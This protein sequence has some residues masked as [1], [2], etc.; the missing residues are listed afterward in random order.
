LILGDRY[1]GNLGIPEVVLDAISQYVDVLSVQYF[2]E[3]TAE[4]RRK[5]RE[6]LEGW[7]RRCGKPVLIADIGNWC[8]THHNPERVSDLPDQRARAEDY[9]AAFEAV[10]D[11][12]WLIGWHW[13]SY[14]ENYTRGWG[15]K[16]PEDNPYDEL[17]GPIEEYNKSFLA[18][19]ANG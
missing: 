11:A 1:N 10:A 7:H 18:G 3:P 13:C 5:M 9:V 6:D 8:A 17:V 19:R 14:V 4:S 15:L 2:T 12:P 16:D